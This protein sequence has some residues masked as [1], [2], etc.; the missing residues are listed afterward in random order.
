MLLGIPSNEIV[1]RHIHKLVQVFYIYPLSFLFF[2]IWRTQSKISCFRQLLFQVLGET[3]HITSEYL[4]HEAKTVLAGSKVEALET[5]SAKLRRDLI[6]LMDKANTVK[7]K[8]KVLVD[9]LKVESQLIVE[10]DEQL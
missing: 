6:F 5:E 7:E 4:G 1:S 8:A 2:L 3:I 10:K 9:E